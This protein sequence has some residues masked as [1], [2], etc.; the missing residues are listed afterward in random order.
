MCLIT[1]PLLNGQQRKDDIQY[2]L[3]Q[4]QSTNAALRSELQ[5][6]QHAPAPLATLQAKQRD[7]QSDAQKFRDLLAHLS[8]YSGNLHAR[9]DQCSAERRQTEARLKAAQEENVRVKVCCTMAP[10][11]QHYLFIYFVC[12]HRT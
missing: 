8:E 9:H 2:E 6:L 3:S 5:Q 4:I 1:F 11:H 7:L 12:T 10:L